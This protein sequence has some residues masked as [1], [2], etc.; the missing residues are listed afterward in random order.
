M[1]KNAKAFLPYT[2]TIYGI[3]RH[4]MSQEDNNN[5]QSTALVRLWNWRI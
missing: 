5:L 1:M 3:F 2:K 4:I